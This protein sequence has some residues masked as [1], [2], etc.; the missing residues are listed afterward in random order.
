[1]INSTHLPYIVVVIDDNYDLSLE[2]IKSEISDENKWSKRHTT[3]VGTRALS[4]KNSRYFQFLS[5]S[6]YL[7]IY[8]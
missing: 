8:Q 3:L 7:F 4:S 6:F 1:M 2:N 5:K